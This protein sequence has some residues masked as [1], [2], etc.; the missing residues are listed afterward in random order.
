MTEGLPRVEAV[1]RALTVLIALG[2]AGPSG[3]TLTAIAESA[4]ANKSTTYRAL[5]TLRL[6]GFANQDAESGLYS[7]G[8]AAFLLARK[9]MG[10]DNLLR[11]LHPVIVAISNEVDELVHLGVPMDSGMLYIDKVEREHAIRVWS[12]VGEL[13]PMATSSLGRAVLAAQRTPDEHL[14]VYA[15]QLPGEGADLGRLIEAVHTARRLGYAAEW[16]ERQPGVACVGLAVM[17]A[18]LTVGAI[19]I[20]TLAQNMTPGRAHELAS[21]ARR[22]GAPLLPDGFSFMEPQLEGQ[23]P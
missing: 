17:R 23:D 13:I 1:D 2:E 4:G 6:R 9:A 18:E 3:S 16:G 19:S 5:S 12:T 8:P 22:V 20:T 10:P 14:N 11:A 15:G 21:A 7:L